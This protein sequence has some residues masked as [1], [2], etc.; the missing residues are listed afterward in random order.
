MENHIAMDIM[1]SA[2]SSEV[3][4]RHGAPTHQCGPSCIGTM[5]F[6]ITLALCTIFD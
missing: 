2:V 5:D 6:L 3:E 1:F 4:L